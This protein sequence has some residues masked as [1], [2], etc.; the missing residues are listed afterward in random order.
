ME[1]VLY[2]NIS[3]HKSMS[4]FMAINGINWKNSHPHQTLGENDII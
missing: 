2:S 4:P 3:T 1:N